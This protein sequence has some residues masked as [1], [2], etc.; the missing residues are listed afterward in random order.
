MTIEMAMLIMP[1]IDDNSNDNDNN[2]ASAN[3]DYQ[4]V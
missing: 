4:I 1:P 2:N 3:N